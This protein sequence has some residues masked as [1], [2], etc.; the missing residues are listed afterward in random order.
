MHGRI[1][2]I[3][4]KARAQRVSDILHIYTTYIVGSLLSLKGSGESQNKDW[5]FPKEDVII[6]AG[7]LSGK[8]KH[9]I[10]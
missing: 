7:N 1:L 9:S 10:I 3:L 6:T 5:S 4:I 8:Q 2:L